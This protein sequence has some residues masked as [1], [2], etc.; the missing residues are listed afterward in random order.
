MSLTILKLYCS[1]I[2][3][4]VI[5]GVKSILVGVVF[6]EEI[7]FELGYFLVNCCPILPPILVSKLRLPTILDLTVIWEV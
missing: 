5:V 4:V 7:D 1:N 2:L 3:L 6:G